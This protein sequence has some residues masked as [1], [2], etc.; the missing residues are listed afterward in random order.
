MNMNVER[1]KIL[2][3][4]DAA[5]IL[6]RLQAILAELEQVSSEAVLSAEIALG[7]M[8][9]YDPDVMVLDINMPGMNGIDLLK[10]VRDSK[11]ISPIIIMLTDNSLSTYREECMR[12]GAHY[13]LDK[14]RDFLMISSI[15]EN[16]QKGKMLQA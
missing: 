7:M 13:F 3:I 10:K 8:E 12:L 14:S 15:I 2:V 9:G 4:D 11:I 5:I 6:H 1:L 16:I